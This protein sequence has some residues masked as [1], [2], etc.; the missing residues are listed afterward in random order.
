MDETITASDIPALVERYHG[1]LVRYAALHL[2][3][4]AAEDATQETWLRLWRMLAEGT[5]PRQVGV[6]AWLYKVLKHRLIDVARHE[7][8]FT[9]LPLDDLGGWEPVREEWE[10]DLGEQDAIERVLARMTAFF[11]EALLMQQD[12]HSVFEIAARFEVQPG[13]MRVHLMRA[14]R[15]AAALYEKES[16]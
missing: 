11:R 5:P 14:R 3:I 9:M 13:T 1:A 15:Q 10:A 7:G 8:L 16:A 12:G 2:G 4:D 6:K